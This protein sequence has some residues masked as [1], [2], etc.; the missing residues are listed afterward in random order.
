MEVDHGSNCRKRSLYANIMYQVVDPRK[1]AEG[2]EKIYSAIERI[3]KEQLSAAIV[4]RSQEFINK[5]ISFTATEVESDVQQRTEVFGVNVS[6]L[7]IDPVVPI[8]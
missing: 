5:N 8:T 7:K 6:E 3:L 4:H 1:A 2:V